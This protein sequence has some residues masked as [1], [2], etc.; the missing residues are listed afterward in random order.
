[1]TSSEGAKETLQQQQHLGVQQKLK[2]SIIRQEISYKIKISVNKNISNNLDIY[3][4][5]GR[6]NEI[7]EQAFVDNMIQYGNLNL[8]H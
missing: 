6:W 4:P 1:M 5:L 2:Q 7:K 8:V 3:S